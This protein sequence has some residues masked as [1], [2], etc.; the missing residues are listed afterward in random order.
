[1]AHLILRP[2]NDLK[3]GFHDVSTKLSPKKFEL[4][5]KRQLVVQI[6]R[7][8]PPFFNQNK[9]MPPEKPTKKL[10]TEEKTG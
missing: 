1:M 10:K 3:N 4:L 9:V 2:D 6:S 7:D 8:I 5:E